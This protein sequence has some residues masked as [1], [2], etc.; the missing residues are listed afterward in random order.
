MCIK[1]YICLSKTYQ[2][3]LNAEATILQL[4]LF[5]AYS[6]FALIRT[7]RVCQV[8]INGTVDDANL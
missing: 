3:K 4:L 1:N 7:V 8:Q 6:T 2:T 5:T